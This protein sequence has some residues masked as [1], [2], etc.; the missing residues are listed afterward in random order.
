MRLMTWESR[1]ALVW[2]N[3]ILPAF[4]LGIRPSGSGFPTDAKCTYW[5]NGIVAYV[6]TARAKGSVDSNHYHLEAYVEK[7]TQSQSSLPF[8]VGLQVCWQ[9]QCL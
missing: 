7:R 4:V 6:K 1:I 2:K 8:R 3:L 5:M 9:G